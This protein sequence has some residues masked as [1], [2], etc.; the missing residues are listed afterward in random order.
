M[1][2]PDETLQKLREYFEKRDDVVLAYL[3]GS[4]A[5]GTATPHRSDYDI[6][7]YFAT[8][9]GTFEYEAETGEYQTESAIWS[10]LE[11]I[12]HEDIDLVVLNRAPASVVFSAINGTE[13]LA[14]KDR[15]LFMKLLLKSSADAEDYAEMVR[16]YAEI[17]ARSRSLSPQDILRLEKIM[18][19]MGNEM[20]LLEQ[21]GAIS[22]I[23][24]QQD[25]RARRVLERSVEMLVNAGLDIAKILLASGRRNIPDKYAEVMKNLGYLDNF[26]NDTA[27][28]LSRSATLRNI[29]AHEYLDLEYTKITTFLTG[30]EKYFTYL[31]QYAKEAV[32]KQ[33][34]EK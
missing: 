28:W 1:K 11:S 31:M 12:T 4:Q 20:I 17:A 23:E 19:F 9:S 29:V 21:Y 24:F 13:V 2:A 5:K 25:P 15:D 34:E 27:L 10:D 3:F 6:A 32:R 22:Q 18:T 7:V 16:D 33:R 14:E 8:P 26:D 30:K